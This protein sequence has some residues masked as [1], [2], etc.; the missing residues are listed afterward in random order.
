MLSLASFYRECIHWVFLTFLKFY[1]YAYS[2]KKVQL[3]AL[4]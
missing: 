3:L 1:N 4:P 2:G